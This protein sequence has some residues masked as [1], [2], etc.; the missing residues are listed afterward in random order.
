MAPGKSNS[1]TRSGVK[2]EP[3][4]IE[5]LQLLFERLAPRSR[6]WLH[7]DLAARQGPLP[8]DESLNGDAHARAVLLGTSETLN[9]VGG[10]VQLGTWQR[11]FLIELDGCRRRT[12]SLTVAGLAVASEESP[13][14][15]PDLLDFA[16][17]RSV[18]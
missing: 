10:E 16:N 3:L 7:D 6:R 14:D 11:V 9:V 2:N 4:L 1:A 17:L 12:I 8:P 15:Y 13:T 5:D 18:S